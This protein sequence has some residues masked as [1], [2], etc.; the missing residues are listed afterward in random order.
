LQRIDGKTTVAAECFERLSFKY[1]LFE[2]DKPVFKS[3][4][5]GIPGKEYPAIFAFE[6]LT[7]ISDSPFNNS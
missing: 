3:L 1:P 2:P 6:P 4:M 5:R 7:I